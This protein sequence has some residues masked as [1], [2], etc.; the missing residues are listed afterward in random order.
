MKLR[1]RSETRLWN[2]CRN[3]SSNINKSLWPFRWVYVSC[4]SKLL[5]YRPVQGRV[6]QHRLV[7][8]EGPLKRRWFTP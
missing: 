3:L 8:R 2:Y 6:A 5:N 7:W 1:I 4:R